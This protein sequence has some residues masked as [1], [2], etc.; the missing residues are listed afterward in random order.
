VSLIGAIALLAVVLLAAGAGLWLLSQRLRESASRLDRVLIETASTR[1]ASESI[2]RRFEDLR[3]SVD[4]R[5]GG[6]EA[7]LTTGQRH[8]SE[9][10]G[11]SGLLLKDVGEKM[12]R[13]YEASQKIEKLAGEVTRLEDLLKPPKLRGTLGETF[14]E[15]ALRQALP[16]GSWQ[17]Q[18]R[19]A[20][21]GMVV[22]AIVLLGDRFVPVDSKFPLENFRR[23]REVEDETERRRARTA[24]AADV[25]RH[26][27]GIARKYIRPAAGTYDY[28]FMYIPAEAVYSEIIAEDDTKALAD[29]CIEQRVFPVSPRL[30]YAY[31]STVAMVLRGQE[32]QRSAQDVS[33]KLAELARLWER[34]GEPFKKVGT[35]LGN[36]QKQYEEAS[37]CLARFGRR[38]TGVS[39]RAEETLEEIVEPLSLLPP[40]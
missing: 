28:A 39:E 15:Q 31:L 17:M 23:S 16:P 34:A 6:V 38:L 36:A 26:A 27:D 25:R 18:Y 35:H 22:D 29:Y 14:L 8:V 37:T 13:I 19:F 32:L 1:Q 2:D 10:L 40:S 7:S 33:E 4:D 11:Q 5:V 20:D 12:G 3:R 30:L 24:F 9:H 21:D